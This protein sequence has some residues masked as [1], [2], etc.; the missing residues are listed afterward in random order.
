LFIKGS[1]PEKVPDGNRIKVDM[2]VSLDNLEAL[3]R[4][5]GL[6]QAATHTLK[7][8]PIIEWNDDSETLHYAWWAD[9]SANLGV[10]VWTKFLN[11]L[12]AKMRARNI[13]VIDGL[14][15]QRVSPALR[16]RNLTREEQLAL[17]RQFD[18]NLVLVGEIHL[19]K[20]EGGDKAQ[21]QTELV[22]VRTNETL[23]NKQAL[24]GPFKGVPDAIIP[25]V[26]D[27]L[28]DQV[29]SVQGAG[30]M[31]IASLKLI[32]RGDLAFL[33]L[34]QLKKE[35][36]AQVVDIRTLKDRMY[37]HSEAVFAAESNRSVSELAQA[38]KR[39][40]FTKMK[41]DASTS[42][43]DLVLNVSAQ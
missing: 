7:L 14:D 18:S 35:L 22:D 28:N 11:S 34:E 23:G 41:V 17:A 39:A 12:T 31:N 24:V 26:A 27:A 25:R 10:K 20:A 42:G 38:V 8:I 33:Q 19:S 15:V 13:K 4:E 40:H 5:Q 36:M 2:K 30:R 9:D 3:L 32:I 21:L 43:S 37:S 16:K 6:L 1:N 29:K